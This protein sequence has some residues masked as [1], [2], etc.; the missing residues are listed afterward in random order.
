MHL[1]SLES[2]SKAFPE[3]PVL[4][5][6]SLGITA[7]ERIAVIGRNGSG[8][9]TLLRIVAGLETPD[10][11]EVIRSNELRISALDQDPRFPAGATVG[12]VVGDDR[13]S[14]A[15]ADRLGLADPE[16]RVAELSGGQR[17]RLAIAVALAADGNLLI[18]DE[19]TNH[20]DVDMIEW[21]EDH[22]LGR[23][24]A[25]L[26]VTHDRYLLD[27]VATRV[28]EV[29]ERRLFPHQGGYEDYLAAR[30]AREEQE[31]AAERRRR[32]RQRVELE[33]LRRS[34]KARTSK[35]R[36]RVKQAEELLAAG[37]PSAQAEVDFDLPA[38]RIG[39]KV[40]N[41][42][43]AGKRFGE[44]WVLRGVT[45]RLARDARVGVV[46]PNGSG[47]TTLLR[48]IAGELEPDEGKVTRGSTIVA[49]WYGQDPRPIPES[50]RVLAAVREVA[51]HTRVADGITVSAPQLL[52][53]FLFP[54]E[55]QKALV[56]ELSGGERRRLEL[57]LVLM[58]APNLLLLDEPTNDLDLDTLEALEEYLDGW[59]GALVVASH[60]RYF[61]DRVCSDVFSIEPD[62]T[63]LHHPGGWAA[64]RAHRVARRPQVTERQASS[65]R[66]RS[67]RQGLT[68]IAQ[69]E[70]EQLDARIAELEARRA[71]LVV[72]LDAAG[73][74]YEAAA[75]VGEELRAV[76]AELDAAETRW[77]ELSEQAGTG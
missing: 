21:L 11:G 41:L 51:E 52:E 35:A 66:R 27:R 10:A 59:A 58:E 61:L 50:T 70:L 7:R 20:L 42:H 8:K 62:G 17:K 36:Y 25:L 34:P 16:A 67:P 49:G 44:R 45:H 40:V 4:D 29:A 72:E 54:R 33:W 46:G 77:L 60:D 15:L 75:R 14:I 30:L 9:S 2:V 65:P 6:V 38:R 63:V 26:L 5:D 68:Y 39:S 3:N 22:L 28:V 73:A 18:L 64:Y 74:D 53:R 37:R 71:A 76:L 1:L 19:P 13:R 69:F 31:A 48:L 24:S 56:G 57:M 43:N 23:A 55:Q 47:K 32:Q 12:A